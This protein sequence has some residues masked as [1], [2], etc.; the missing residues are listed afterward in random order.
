MKPEDRVLI[1]NSHSCEAHCFAKK[2]MTGDKNTFECQKLN[3]LGENLPFAKHYA[4]MTLL[5][6]ALAL[7]ARTNHLLHEFMD[8][9]IIDDKRYHKNSHFDTRTKWMRLPVLI[10]E[11]K[12]NFKKDP[13]KAISDILE[14]RNA[15]VHSNFKEHE[16]KFVTIPSKGRTIELYD[17]CVIAMEEMN[18]LLKRIPQVRKE[19][20]DKLLLLKKI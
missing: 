1:W 20:L 9:K 16:G 18:V 7:E 8:Q 19:Y 3:L 4:L 17:N 11:N 13:H 5:H 15:F 10:G 14:F 2:L 6:L 12:I